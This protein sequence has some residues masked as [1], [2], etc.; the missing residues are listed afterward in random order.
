LHTCDFS[1]TFRLVRQSDPSDGR[2]EVRRCAGLV[3][4]ATRYEE[5]VETKSTGACVQVR[6]RVHLLPLKLAT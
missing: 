2:F 1:I 6:L 3:D 5:T 4:T